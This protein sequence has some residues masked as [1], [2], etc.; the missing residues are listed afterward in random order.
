MTQPDSAAPHQALAA[1]PAAARSPTASRP[2]RPRPSSDASAAP[3]S[4][5]C[6]PRALDRC[7]PAADGRAAG[8]PAAAAARL[9]TGE[10]RRGPSAA[11]ADRAGA[12]GPAG[13]TEAAAGPAAGGGWLPAGGPAVRHAHRVPV[14]LRTLGAGSGSALLPRPCHR[15][16]GGGA[17]RR[18]AT[19]PGGLP[20]RVGAPTTAQGCRD[21]RRHGAGCAPR[22]ELRH[23]RGPLPTTVRQR[24]RASVRLGAGAPARLV[25]AAGQGRRRDRTD[26]RQR[27]HRP[28]HVGRRQAAR[29][30]GAA[31]PGRAAAGHRQPGRAGRRSSG[32]AP[33]GGPAAHRGD[34]LVD[35]FSEG[36]GAYQRRAVAGG[37][38]AIDHG[39]AQLPGSR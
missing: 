25:L 35:R 22:R 10:R 16:R 34:R 6:A 7:V 3:M 4:I 11:A 36:A 5:A 38:L 2:V 14:P 31:V 30:T 26:G 23:G 33:G 13:P 37:L 24:R 19:T 32:A 18:R 27:G 1:E 9:A 12:A 20:H 15:R 17:R 28:A 29:S 8:N 21:H 39:P